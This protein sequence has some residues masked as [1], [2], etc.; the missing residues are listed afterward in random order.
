MGLA[1]VGFVL[2]SGLP[3]YVAVGAWVVA[4]LGLPINDCL[5]MIAREVREPLAGEFQLLIEA[6]RIG[7]PVEQ[8]LERMTQ[9]MPTAEVNFFAIVLSIQ[10]Q[11]GGNLVEVLGNLSKVLR[12]R[13]KMKCKIRGLS[14][15]AK[16]SARCRSPSCSSCI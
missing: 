4:S 8:C 5:Q 15:E 2:S 6:Q 14:Q 16:S 11:S 10:K 9:R 13:K 12:D 1:V 7:V 3:V